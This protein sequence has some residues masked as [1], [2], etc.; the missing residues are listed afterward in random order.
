MTQ[1]KRTRKRAVRLT[2]DALAVLESALYERWKADRKPAKLTREARARYLG[3]SGITADRILGGQGV[4][5]ATLMLAFKS[6][7]LR[8]CNGYCVAEPAAQAVVTDEAVRHSLP[9]TGRRRWLPTMLVIVTLCAIGALGTFVPARMKPV[10]NSEP[11]FGDE[12]HLLLDVGTFAFQRADYRTAQTSFDA[13]IK[14]AREHNV[15]SELANSLRLSG[16]VCA[17]QGNFSVA[18]DRY[19]ESLFLR[20]TFV[21]PESIPP[22]LEA[23]GDVETKLRRFA[24]ANVHLS[25]SLRLYRE[26]GDR[27][28][29]AMAMR[30][31][32][33]L[34]FEQGD[35]KAANRW[36]ECALDELDGPTTDLEIDI[37]ARLALV[38]RDCGRLAQARDALLQ[39][40][41]H[42]RAR[43]HPR[44]CAVTNLQ[45]GTVELRLGGSQVADAY[46]RR[47]RDGFA[48]VGDQAGVRTAQTW[49]AKLHG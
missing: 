28:G 49:L 19:R 27:G 43:G 36:F 32:G 12:L 14:L 38:W 7:G 4:D 1:P 2:A 48:A 39:C 9:N 45:L 33:T 21:V 26:L 40:L 5:R 29:V 11:Y 47:S 20:K 25:T 16:D 35:L 3:V 37:R 41:S 17:A 23:M 44:W 34:A 13:A 42:W 8:W 15:G 46:L 22:V 18:L 30:D 24:D 10:V 31:L 6:L